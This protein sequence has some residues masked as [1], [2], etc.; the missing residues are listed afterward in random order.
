MSR[1]KSPNQ[2]VNCPVFGMGSWRRWGG[3]GRCAAEGGQ[4]LARTPRRA[5]GQGFLPRPGLILDRRADQRELPGQ[6]RHQITP[7][8]GRGWNLQAWQSPEQALLGEAVPLYN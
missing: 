7:A 5:R 6:E 3:G 2:R 4:A 8:F 1:K